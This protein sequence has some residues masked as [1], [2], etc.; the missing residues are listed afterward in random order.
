MRKELEKKSLQCSEP[1][2]NLSTLPVY[3]FRDKTHGNLSSLDERIQPFEQ[4]VGL[5]FVSVACWMV[6]SALLSRPVPLR[7]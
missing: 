6:S 1:L 3:F 5:R 4:C 2:S 7:F